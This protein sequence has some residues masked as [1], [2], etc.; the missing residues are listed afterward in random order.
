[1]PARRPRQRAATRIFEVA[2]AVVLDDDDAETGARP[3]AAGARQLGEHERARATQ[4]LG[5]DAVEEVAR[6]RRGGEHLER[7]ERLERRLGA[8]R[9]GVEE[10]GNLD[11]IGA[12]VAKARA[13][14]EDVRR[15]ALEQADGRE[16][17]DV[18]EWNNRFADA[19]R[20]RGDRLVVGFVNRNLRHRPR[21]A[22][23]QSDE[24]ERGHAG[25][26]APRR[27]RVEALAE[28]EHGRADARHAR[29]RHG[30]GEQRRGGDA[31]RDRRR[32]RCARPRRPLSSRARETS[33]R[34]RVARRAIVQAAIRGDRRRRRPTM[35]PRFRIVE[36]P[37]H[38]RSRRRADR[39]AHHWHDRAACRLPFA[40]ARSKSY[41]RA[42]AA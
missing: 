41:R 8:A 25:E 28:A 1:M 17:G 42:R 6:R 4:D 24:D 14:D 27:R 22:A 2:G 35:E 39:L 40:S 12:L 37:F 30:L 15:R 18:A 21:R 32:T 10:R 26:P 3:H 20:A 7:I 38:C 31:L 13:L 16:P 36:R 29:A 33:F 34:R 11:G 19:E 5:G 23:A 9:T